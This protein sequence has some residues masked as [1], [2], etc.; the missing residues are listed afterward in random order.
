M[1]HAVD[2]AA[3]T[4]LRLG[5]LVRLSWSHVGEDAIVIR[6]GKSKQRREAI[7]PLYDESRAPAR[8]AS[9]GARPPS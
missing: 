4:G 7:I 9:R 1:A 5:D 8:I 3:H 2:L 6:T